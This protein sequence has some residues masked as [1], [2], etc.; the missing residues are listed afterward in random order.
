MDGWKTGL[1]A[2]PGV[3]GRRERNL[4]QRSAPHTE[5]QRLEAGERGGEGE[6][7]RATFPYYDRI[8]KYYQLCTFCLFDSCVLVQDC[9]KLS[10]K[11]MASRIGLAD[12]IVNVTAPSRG[13]ETATLAAAADET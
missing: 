1:F 12:P 8:L 6:Q 5:G 3:V 7:G 13:T 9:K 10:C 11:N 4:P 2:F